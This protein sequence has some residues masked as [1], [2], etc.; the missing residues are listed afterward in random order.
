MAEVIGTALSI[1]GAVGILG[2]IFDGCIKAY[3]FFTTA[4]K[5]RR[6][7]ELL[8]CKTQIDEMRLSIWAENGE[9]WMGS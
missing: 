9:L 4:S 3:E 6:D 1:I 7:S 5:L 2:Q 8:V